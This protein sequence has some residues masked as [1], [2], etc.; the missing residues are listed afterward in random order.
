MKCFIVVIGMIIQLQSL[1]SQSVNMLTDKEKKEGW[2]LLFNGQNFNGWHTYGNKPVG[3][4]WKINDGVLELHTGLQDGGDLVTNEI[5]KGNFEFKIDW[6]ISPSSNS[7]IFLFSKESAENEFIYNTALELQIQDNN[8]YRHEKEDKKHLTGDL[9]GII[10]ANNA[11]PNK[12]GEWNNYHIIY[13]HPVL[14]VFLN[15]KRIHHINLT[16]DAWKKLVGDNRRNS[17]FAQGTFAG[18]IG[19]QDWHSKV[20]FKNIKL[21]KLK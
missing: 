19:L 7:G 6:K 10:K 16:S 1:K 4:R 14:D 18:P 3:P 2:E 13:K 8:V 15:N 21:R 9:F 17:P 20:W 11:Q 5:I 12:L